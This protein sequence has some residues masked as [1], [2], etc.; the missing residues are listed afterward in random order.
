[1]NKKNSYKTLYSLCLLVGLS[2]VLYY[3]GRFVNS[4][5]TKEKTELIA[6]TNNPYIMILGTAQDG[7]SLKRAVKKNA[8]QKLGEIKKYQKR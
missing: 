2:I 4:K 6:D 5:N 3:A 8:A 7:V 1:M